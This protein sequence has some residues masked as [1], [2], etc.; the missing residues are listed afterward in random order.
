MRDLGVKMNGQLN[1]DDVENFFNSLREDI[2]LEGVSALRLA[3][4][5]VRNAFNADGALPE[6]PVRQFGDQVSEQKLLRSYCLRLCE[7]AP[8]KAEN[9]TCTAILKYIK[10]NYSDI[11]LSALTI[12]EHFGLSEK[13][14]YHLVRKASNKSLGEI[15][16]ST[17][18]NKACDYLLQTDMS[19]EEISM[20]VGFGTVNTFYRIFKKHYGVSPR[21]W[22]VSANAA[23]NTL[24]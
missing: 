12:G 7:C 19:N 15:I 10:D 11:N 3:I 17:R 4:N 6:L 13:Y 8:Q 23:K 2:S 5:E 22:S 16:E 20:S 21:T 9:D 24:I 14:V 18:M 1:K